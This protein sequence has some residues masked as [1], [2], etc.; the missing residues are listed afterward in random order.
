MKSS[1]NFKMSTVKMQINDQITEQNRKIKFLFI[2][3]VA[4]AIFV[5]SCGVVLLVLYLV[6]SSGTY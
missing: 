4:G 6:E 3:M 1:T 5:L 2:A